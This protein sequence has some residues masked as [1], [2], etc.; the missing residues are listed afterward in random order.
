VRGAD[1]IKPPVN[2]Y[3]L[4]SPSFGFFV[5]F[6]GTVTASNRPEANMPEMP[7]ERWVSLAVALAGVA[8]A[9]WLFDWELETTR[10]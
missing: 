7:P 1:G 9:I 8:V 6:P 3:Q 4:S 2:G 5:R 10:I